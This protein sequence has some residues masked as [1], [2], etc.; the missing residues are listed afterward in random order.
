MTFMR[1]F[2]FSLLLAPAATAWANEAAITARAV[3]LKKTPYTDA[4]TLASLPEETR[5]EIISRQ[6]AWNQVKDGEARQGWVKMLSLRIDPGTEKK[7]GESGLG[8]LFNVARSGSSGSTVATGV[9]GLSEKDLRNA[10]PN[11]KELERLQHLTASTAEARLFAAQA[12]LKSR[13]IS[14]LAGGKPAASPADT[15]SPWEKNQ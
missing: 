9:R 8:A 3:D 12:K 5:V 7:S 13:S 2:L 4:E 6:G 1:L 14:Y 11:F 15:A 10:Q